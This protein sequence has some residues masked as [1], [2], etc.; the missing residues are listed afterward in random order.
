MDCAMDVTDK[1]AKP[2]R[3]MLAVLTELAARK[4]RGDTPGTR[5]ELA[6]LLDVSK[7]AISGWSKIP[8]RHVSRV[9]HVLSIPAHV[10]RPDVFPAPY[11]AEAIKGRGLRS[12]AIVRRLPARGRRGTAAR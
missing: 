12:K 3:G 5:T 6:E 11:A 10:L 4:A 8:P 7:Q 9:A 1:P 2:D